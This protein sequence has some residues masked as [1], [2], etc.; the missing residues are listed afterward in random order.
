MFQEISNLINLVVT[1]IISN[2]VEILCVTSVLFKGLLELL[3]VISLA[4]E[5]VPG[6]QENEH[7][8]NGDN[9]ILGASLKKVH[10]VMTRKEDVSLEICQLVSRIYTETILDI[11]VCKAEVNERHFAIVT[12]HDVLGLNV[13]ISES[14]TMNH[15][16]NSQELMG[17]IEN[18]FKSLRAFLIL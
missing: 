13:I 3:H 15:F 4:D 11:F 5:L 8:K 17:Y 1:L 16:E 18:I 2:V 12:D 7:I 10:L 6:Q 14:C 9:V